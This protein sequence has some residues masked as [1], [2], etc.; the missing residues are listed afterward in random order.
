MRF[1]MKD[2]IDTSVKKSG[3]IRPHSNQLR[4]GFVS[5]GYV[6]LDLIRFYCVMLGLVR[7]FAPQ[8]FLSICPDNLTLI[9]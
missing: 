2:A 4:L 3:Q 1:L 7:L 8:F 6:R 5:L 9:Q